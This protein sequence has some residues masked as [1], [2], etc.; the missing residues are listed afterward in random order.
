MSP[1]LAIIAIYL[2]LTVAIGVWSMRRT[3]GA[4]AFHGTG[5]GVFACVAAGAG[6][7][8]G[9]TST[10]GCSS[11]GYS[12]G[13]SG[14]WYT[15]ANGIGIMV[16]ALCFATLYRSLETITVPGLLEHFIGVHPRVV[17]SVILTFVMIVVGAAQIIAAGSLAVSVLGIPYGVS[18]VILGIAFIACTLA[19]GMRAVASTNILHLAAMYGGIV[20]A[21]LLLRRD[22]GGSFAPLQTGLPAFP[23]WSWVGIGMP[24]VTSWIIASV[25]GACTAQAGIQPLLAARDVHVAKRSAI[26]TAGI[27]APFG[28][29]TALIGMAAK[30]KFPSLAPN[31]AMP[32]LLMHMDPVAGG[33]VLASILAAI[34][35]TISP[36]ILA[37]GTM[38]SKDIYQRLL[39]PD[40]T[41]RQVFRFSR[42]ATGAAGV[43]TIAIAMLP[44]VRILDL[45]YFAY[46]LRG[47]IFVVIL[48]GI[49][50]RA[51]SPKGA[52]WSMVATAGVGLFW[53]LWKAGT[54]SFPIHPALT[55]TYAAVMAALVLTPILSRA[56]PKAHGD[57]VAR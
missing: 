49:Y 11:Y 46:T 47:S 36:I 16:L 35:S 5:L 32:T 8:L 22:L 52:V 57:A 34:L 18:C 45:V 38:A 3:T 25:L 41:D 15:I 40:A 28:V 29:F 48:F 55:E 37:A 12:S 42:L 27:V 50:W 43:C 9:G 23:Y 2:G 24:K 4:D 10:I 44:D 26:I 30:A 1:Q 33:V 51:T 56:F 20:V 14:G 13:L 31:L 17:A 53:V 6:E 21:L 39:R 7:W 54:G 19:G